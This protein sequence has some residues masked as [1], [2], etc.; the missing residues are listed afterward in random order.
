MRLAWLQIVKGEELQQLA[1]NNRMRGIEVKAKRGTIYDR[2]GK[3]LAVSISADT[4]IAV[5]SQVRNSKR[6][7][8]IAETLADILEL[9]YDKVFERITKFSS[10]EFVQRKIDFD[11]ARQ[12][13][14]L[15]LPGITII[16]ENQR[17][18]PKGSLAAHM[19]G[20]AG[21]DNQGLEGIEVTYEEKLKGVP[22]RIEVEYDARGR[23][24]PQATHAYIPPQPGYN[25][26]LT[27]DE[28]IQ[29]IVERELDKAIQTTQAKSATIILMDP[30]TGGILALASRPTYDPNQFGQYPSSNWRNIA[31][32][33]SYEPGSTYKIITLAA[34]I[35]EGLFDPDKTFHDPGFIKVGVE[36]IRCWKAGGHGTQTFREVVENSCNPGFITLGLRLEEKSKGLLYQYVKGFGFGSPT[37]IKLPGE[38]K[39]IMI[40]E[41]DLKLINVATISMGQAIAITPLQLVTAVAA[42]A[43][44]GLLLEPQLVKEIRDEEGRLIEVIN[45]K[46]V[47][48]VVSKETAALARDMLASVVAN[49]TGS[50]AYLPGYRVAG[51]TGTAQKAE[52]GRYV[53]GKYVASFVGFAPADNPQVVGLVVIDEPIGPYYGGQIAAPVFKNVI[54]DV[55]RYLEVEP[56]YS[57][58]E[59]KTREKSLQSLVAI[60][61]IRN[62]TKTEAEQKLRASGLLVQFSGEG[63][64]VVAQIPAAH[65]RV[66]PQTRVV[67]YLD[68]DSD[69]IDYNNN[70]IVPD[71]SGL[72][73]REVAEVFN[74]LGLKLEIGQDSTGIA[75]QQSISVGSRVPRGTVIKVL[76]SLP[77]GSEEAFAG[78]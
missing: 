73:I 71:T 2:N 65:A 19:L 55:L 66:Q 31:V 54:E 44:D 36:T 51:K 10:F 27:I 7:E 43:N 61:D 41:K 76:F 15:N 26:I 62:L 33:N 60:P 67:I 50:N 21:I 24:I 34:A 72:T 5:P 74:A 57:P 25:L 39:G 69:E 9:D 78:P 38:A 46:S 6:A 28:V 22:G 70:V 40:P 77:V 45:P 16:E 48:Q 20:F 8:E 30:K 75:V 23:E 59:L 37:G 47:H 11:K 52:G 42:I 56:E 12:I 1:E 32:A 64:K 14:E 29:Y 17:F 3:E 18:Y 68:K 13:K 58:E 53:Q 49:G 4:V 35:E 63:E